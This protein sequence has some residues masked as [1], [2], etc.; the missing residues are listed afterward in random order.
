MSILLN[1][2]NPKAAISTTM[3]MKKVSDRLDNN[4]YNN[5]DC[6]TFRSANETVSK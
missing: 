1:M 6:G 3:K 2:V 4:I 5:R